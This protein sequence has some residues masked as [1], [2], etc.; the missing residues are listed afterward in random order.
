MSSSSGAE[1]TV[2][3]EYMFARLHGLWSHL[4]RGEALEALI[5]SEDEEHLV[6]QLRGLGIECEKYDTFHRQLKVR[7]MRMLDGIRRQVGGAVGEFYRALMR[8]QFFTN[9]KTL[10]HQR[11][12][13]FHE[14]RHDVGPQLVELPFE[15][16]ID[17]EAALNPPPHP[18]L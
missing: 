5:R 11:S 10:L 16:P 2:S 13:Y 17:V 12:D 14:H 9:V 8:H 18:G 3:H 6:R 15:E 4:V 1:I 7:E